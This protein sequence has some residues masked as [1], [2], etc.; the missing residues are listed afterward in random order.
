MAQ[1][2]GRYL[3]ALLLCSA[4]PRDG[5]EGDVGFSAHLEEERRLLYVGM[6]RA[7]HCL[8]ILCPLA[9]STNQM[10]LQPSRFLRDIGAAHVKRCRHDEVVRVGASTGRTT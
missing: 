9:D 6:S 10:P 1:S 7:R 4:R 5:E 8:N 3:T 2:S